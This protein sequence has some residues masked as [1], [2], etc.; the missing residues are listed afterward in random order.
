MITNLSKIS[1]LT[2]TWQKKKKLWKRVIARKT[3]NNFVLKYSKHHSYTVFCFCF[4]VSKRYAFSP[5]WITLKNN[6]CM[7]R[8]KIV[9]SLMGEYQHYYITESYEYT[10]KWLTCLLIS[11]CSLFLLVSEIS[12]LNKF[13]FKW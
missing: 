9:A 8:A 5:F 4:A 11:I 12:I 13:H 2:L 7:I 3:K 6:I 10:F 1:F